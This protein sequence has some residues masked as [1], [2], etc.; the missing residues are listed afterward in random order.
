[1]NTIQ[2]MQRYFN[3]TDEESREVTVYFKVSAVADQFTHFRMSHNDEW[4]PAPSW[5]SHR[6]QIALMDVERWNQANPGGKYVLMLMRGWIGYLRRMME[7]NRREKFNDGVK[8]ERYSINWATCEGWFRFETKLTDEELASKLMA[9]HAQFP[10]HIID[11]P[12]Q[13]QMELFGISL[14]APT[15]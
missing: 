11:N 3:N 5:A 6:P 2:E 15:Q 13:R 4:I 1:M 10:M 7:K 9:I 8:L 14:L 12:A